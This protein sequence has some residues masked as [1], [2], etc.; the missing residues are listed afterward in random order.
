MTEHDVL[1][2]KLATDIILR[3]FNPYCPRNTESSSFQVFE[4]HIYSFKDVDIETNRITQLLSSSGVKPGSCV[5]I[6]FQNSPQAVMAQ[7]AVLKLGAAV[8]FLNFNLRGAPL[9]HT[10]KLGQSNI[11]FF[12]DTNHDAVESILADLPADIKLIS[13]GFR[14]PSAEGPFRGK[15]LTG[16]DAETLAR[17][18]PDGM[19]DPGIEVRKSIRLN[20]WC[21]IYF[22][23]GTTVSGTRLVLSV[24]HCG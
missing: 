24:F 20:S 6:L 18:F 16:I 10:F 4:D 19:L 21:G 9:L 8:S 22:T 1:S 11:L 3:R 5:S 17:D 23:S 15:N 13:Y 12:E 14:A 2:L 7:I